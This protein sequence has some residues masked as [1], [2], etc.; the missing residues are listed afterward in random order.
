MEY[1]S[2]P[3]F[4]A[5]DAENVDLRAENERLRDFLESLRG[6]LQTGYGAGSE[7]E[8]RELAVKRINAALKRE[9]E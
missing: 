6:F 2:D 5:L 7:T 9:G 3:E 8:I 4:E 1:E